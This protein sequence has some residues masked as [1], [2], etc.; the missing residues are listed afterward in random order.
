MLSQRLQH[1]AVHIQPGQQVREVINCNGDG[2]AIRHLGE[3]VNDGGLSHGPVED[4]GDEDQ[5]KVRAVAVAFGGLVEDITSRAGEA[6][7]RYCEVGAPVAIG[8]LAGLLD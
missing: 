7:D 8:D 3:E 5:G 1:I 2:R 4:A 6:T